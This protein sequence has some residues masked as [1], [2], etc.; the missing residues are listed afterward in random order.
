MPPPRRISTSRPVSMAAMAMKVSLAPDPR[1]IVTARAARTDLCGIGIDE[2]LIAGTQVQIVRMPLRRQ[3]QGQ[4]AHADQVGAMDALEARGQHRAY[5]EQR[6]RL[7]R[8]SR[9][10]SPC[11]SA[12][13]L[14]RRRSA[15]SSRVALGG[16]PQRQ[17]LAASRHGS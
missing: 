11:H 9:A 2:D 8:P 16:A 3:T 6:R 10:T 15:P 14:P 17:M 1:R 5:A 7:S 12:R 4:D 13:P